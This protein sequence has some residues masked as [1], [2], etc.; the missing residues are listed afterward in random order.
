M[1]RSRLIDTTDDLITDSGAV[2]WSI[3]KG[4]QLEFPV[5]M[6]FVENASAGYS[7]EAVVV[8]ALNITDQ[9]TRPTTIRPNGVQTGL[10]VRVPVIQGAWS[11]STGYFKED[12][13]SYSGKYYRLL[14]GANRISSVLPTQDPLWQE[15]TINKI[16]IQFHK[17]LGFDWN[18]QPGVDSPVYG[19]FELRVTEPNDS[20]F[21]RTWKPIRGMV[22]IL[23][24]PTAMTP[25]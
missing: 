23:F 2:L 21:I 25:D 16:Y 7:Y 5:T 8:E 1:A 12:V 15:T 11:P 3:V 18:V 22:E 10:V 24:S 17:T 20:V 6:N 13:V 19:F 4:E 9:A 14:A